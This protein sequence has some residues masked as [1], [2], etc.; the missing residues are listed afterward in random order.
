MSAIPEETTKSTWTLIKHSPSLSTLTT[1][2]VFNILSIIMLGGFTSLALLTNLFP[3]LFAFFVSALYNEGRLAN[4]T[5][6][7][8]IKAF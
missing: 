4:Q 6:D 3:T 2:A 1:Y 5:K 7:K 8:N